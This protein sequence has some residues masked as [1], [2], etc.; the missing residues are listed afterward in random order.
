MVAMAHPDLRLLAPLEAGEDA[1]GLA[2]GELGA[3]VFALPRLD[4]PPLQVGDELHPVADAEHR[5]SQLEELA[6]GAGHVG[7]VDR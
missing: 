7:I 5:D 2:D 6:L 1:F 3:A 4:L